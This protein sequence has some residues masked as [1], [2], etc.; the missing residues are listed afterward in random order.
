MAPSLATP[1]IK[2]DPDCK[3]LKNIYIIPVYI[4]PVLWNSGYRMFKNSAK[5][6]VHR[7]RK[8][9]YFLHLWFVSEDTNQ[10]TIVFSWAH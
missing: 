6:S 3:F 10:G 7:M 9:L 5:Y 8:L 2:P 4:K 1:T